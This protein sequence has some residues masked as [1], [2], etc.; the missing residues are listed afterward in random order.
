MPDREHPLERLPVFHWMAP[1]L[2]DLKVDIPSC[3]RKTAG[4]W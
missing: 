4:G 1:N 2:C 3:A